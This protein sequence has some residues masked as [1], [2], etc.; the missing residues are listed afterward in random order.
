MISFN[1]ILT[2]IY[3][4]TDDDSGLIAIATAE[5]V[6]KEIVKALNF[7]YGESSK[8]EEMIDNIEKNLNDKDVK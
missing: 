8:V 6:A 7:Y 2:C 3:A 1:S 5:I 4:K